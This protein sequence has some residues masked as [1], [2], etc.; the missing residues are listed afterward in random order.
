MF[1]KAPNKR[2][3]P[4]RPTPSKR[5]PISPNRVS[6]ARHRGS[7]LILCVTVLVIIALVGIAYLQRVRTDQFA[8]DRHERAY[9]NHVIQGILNDVT[10]TL[11]KDV[12]D[13]WNDNHLLYD[14]P[15]TVPNTYNAKADT[16]YTGSNQAPQY[17]HDI[18]GYADNVGPEDD[19][20][21]ASTA[22][23]WYPGGAGEY[24]WLH[25]SNLTGVWLDLPV[26]D[27]PTVPIERLIHFSSGQIGQAD[28]SDTDLAI[29]GNIANGLSY[30]PSS[31]YQKR[32]ADADGDGI[33]DSRWQWV[34]SDVRTIG[35]RKFVMAIRI[36]DLNAMLNVNT[37]TTLFDNGG[38]TSS[39]PMVARGYNPSWVDLSRLMSRVSSVPTGGQPIM[40]NGTRWREELAS[41]LNFRMDRPYSLGEISSKYDNNLSSIFY[42]TDDV[43]EV[44]SEQASIYGNTDRN[45]VIDTEMELRRFG[46]V[47]DNTITSVLEVEMGRPY[48]IT[49]VEQYSRALR[50][51]D[52]VISYLGGPENGYKDVVDPAGSMTS[53]KQRISRWFYGDDGTPID[54]SDNIPVKNRLFPAIRHFITTQSGSGQYAPILQPLDPND[55]FSGRFKVDLRN[56]WDKTDKI[57][58]YLKPVLKRTRETTAG[59]YAGLSFAEIDDL[60]VEYALA[61]KDYSDDDNEPGYMDLPSGGRAYGLEKLPFL[62]EVY[63]QALYTDV[64]LEDAGGLRAGDAGYA[65]PDLFN[66]HWVYKNAPNDTRAMVI[67]LGNPFSHRIRAADLDGRV[68]IVVQHG[69]E[70]S[71]FEFGS[72][73][74][75]SPM[76]PTNIEARVDT[77]T[78]NDEDIL[79]VYSPPDDPVDDDSGSHDGSDLPNDLGFASSGA[80]LLELV[81]GKLKFDVGNQTDPIE[82]ELQVLT[83]D[84]TWVAYDRMTTDPDMGLPAEVPHPPDAASRP[85]HAQASFARRSEKIK[86][87]VEDGVGSDIVGIRDDMQATAT[88]SSTIDELG[89]DSKGVP[90]IDVHPNDPDFFENLQLPLPDRPM[91]SLAEVAQLHMFGFTNTETFSERMAGNRAPVL[92]TAEHFLLINPRDVDYDTTNVYGVPHAA[93]LMDVFT[94]VSPIDDGQDNDNDDGNNQTNNGVDSKY[95]L[96]TPGLINVNTAPMHILAMGSPMGEDLDDTEAYMRSIVAY[97]DEP[98]RQGLRAAG[99]HGNY[100]TATAGL[101]VAN[102]RTPDTGIH[103]KNFPANERLY[104]PGITSLGELLYINPDTTTLDGNNNAL[105]YGEDTNPALPAPMDMYPD[106]NESNKSKIDQGDD[107]EQLLARFG[108]LSQSF[109]VRSDRFAVYCVVRGY[110][111]KKF[112]K[113]PK[114]VAR[115]IAIIDRGIMEDDKEDEP[116]VIGFVRL[117]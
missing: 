102:I 101:T 79:I 20:W 84:G 74:Q 36:V 60:A 9:V 81:G 73:D 45:Y 17:G 92:K 100:W 63:T 19:R 28:R 104:V 115:F 27:G 66:D 44:W 96:F 83:D 6:P 93:M 34:P 22:P 37:A 15:W 82:I 62:R 97:R 48:S 111:D 70:T 23:V 75:A 53:D 43:A 91:N 107:N 69:S 67:E 25:L 38:N 61:I 41:L 50:Q 78:G 55:N 8:T 106:P 12:D 24:R 114:E 56:E 90:D 65:G 71:T 109:T 108:M 3:A 85:R 80:S 1:Q 46:G 95:E 11:K 59:Y 18:N 57:I 94:V 88:Y 29:V 54:Y 2:N 10:D 5:E 72:T 4:S 110:D 103:L 77:G 7:L 52:N 47:N 117:Q 112:N 51:N 13:N 39:V 16:E 113:P 76:D 99:Q 49:S 21:L 14:Y 58:R 40:S 87:V 68:R 35:G 30:A 86:Y 89:S 42:T 98:L 26:K 33:L 116:R 64:D 31:N 105:R 32:G